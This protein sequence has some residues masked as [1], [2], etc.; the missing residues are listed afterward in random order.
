MFV[1]VILDFLHRASN[2]P[3]IR[4][5]LVLSCVHQVSQVLQ[6]ALVLIL[7]GHVVVQSTTPG[8][9]CHHH[10]LKRILKIQSMFWMFF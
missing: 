9:H 10:L 1:Q 2:N 5:H 4:C 7:Q 8:T 6:C 3:L